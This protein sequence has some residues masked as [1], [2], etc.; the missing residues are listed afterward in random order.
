MFK[1][2]KM[3][4]EFNQLRNQAAKD[5]PE[6]DDEECC[7]FAMDAMTQKYGADPDWSSIIQMIIEFIISILPFLF[8]AKESQE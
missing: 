8:L 2:F 4:R 7:A 1:K 6:W 5:H 3:L